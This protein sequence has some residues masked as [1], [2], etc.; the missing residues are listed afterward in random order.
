M[1][2]LEHEHARLAD[3]A[4]VCQTLHQPEHPAL[5]RLGIHAIRG[6]L[7]IGHGEE[8]E[9]QRQVVFERLVEAEK[10]SGDPLACRRV[11]VP[12]ADLEVR[13]QELQHR[14][15]RDR[16][17]VC[18]AR[19]VVDRRALGSP[20]LRE[21]MADPALAHAGLPDDPDHLSLARQRMLQ[22]PLQRAEL[23]LAAD[24]AREATRA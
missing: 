3:T 15:E 6:S 11:G 12:L 17:G 13:A 20:A 2:V 18:L 21:L 24:E 1:E 7:G 5:A 16:L 9:Q 14:H 10:A 8:L 23:F 4:R 22:S 19:D